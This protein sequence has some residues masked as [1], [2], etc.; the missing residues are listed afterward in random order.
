MNSLLVSVIV[1]SYNQ[2]QYIGATIDSILQQDY[3]NLECIVMDGGSTDTTVDVLKRYDDSRLTWVSEK[4]HGQSD[5]INKGMRV[6]KGDLLTFIN[7]DDLLLPGA[8]S[9]IVRYFEQHPNTDAIFGDVQLIAA[10]G[11]PIG[12]MQGQPFDLEA[13]LTGGQPVTQQGSVWR[14][15]VTEKIGLLDDA[16]HFTMDLD[17]WLR[18]ALAG[19]R[20]DYVPGMR[21]AFRR[22]ATSKSTS[23]Q[24]GFLKDW[25][26]MLGK[27]Y[28]DA[29][30]PA[31]IAR[32]KEQS[33]A[34]VDWGWAKTYWM[35]GDY[36]AARP[37]LR[38]FLRGGKRG[39]RVIAAT[40]L[41]D[42]TLHTPLTRLVAAVYRRMT[43]KEILFSENRAI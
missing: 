26:T 20:L 3:P 9:Q 38:R 42:N 12:I 8:L 15:S 16:L 25:A 31:E 6:A 34:F 19:L 41:I 32:L 2:G 33:F 30:I 17:Y 29:R 4:D 27:V 13:A 28:D 24:T 7:S 37:L 43:G 21:A 1:P 36:A 39:R 14:R 23:L 18:I 11:S 35:Q 10:D 40:M 5:A 22:H